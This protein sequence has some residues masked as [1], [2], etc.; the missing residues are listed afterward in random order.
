MTKMKKKVKIK[1]GEIIKPLKMPCE[2]ELRQLSCNLESLQE[3]DQ[4]YIE[5]SKGKTFQ[6]WEEGPLIFFP[7]YKYDK[8]KPHFD[9]SAKMRNPAWTDRILYYAEDGSK[10]G[11]LSPFP[12]PEEGSDG[13]ILG[14]ETYKSVDSR[15]SDHR[16]VMT[17]LIL[18]KL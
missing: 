3:Y 5:R 17:R 4:L 15:A 7:T 9:S 1:P 16:P 10:E 2:E 6:K 11:V 18:N 14:A 12:S 13:S 8:G